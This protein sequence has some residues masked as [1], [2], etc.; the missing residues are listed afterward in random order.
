MLL[1]KKHFI[2]IA[3]LML[4][5][6]SASVIAQAQTDKLEG[7]WYND[8]K[9][10]KVLITRAGNGK[11]YGKVIWLKEPLKMVSQKWMN[12]TPTKSCAAG[13]DL[14]YLYFQIL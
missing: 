3:L 8:I 4:I 12:L 13:Q 5:M 9:S 11:F 6:V 14:V 2:R 1:H 7:L 10:A